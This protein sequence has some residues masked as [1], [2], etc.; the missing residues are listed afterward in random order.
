M[1]LIINDIEY[2]EPQWAEGYS[3]TS[4]RSAEEFA[5]EDGGFQEVVRTERLVS[6]SVNMYADSKWLDIIRNHAISNP[7]TVQCNYP[8]TAALTTRKMRMTLGEES[9]VRGSDDAT[10]GGLWE[11]SFTL[12]AYSPD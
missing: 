8:D 7:V 10:A 3:A 12:K 9:L 11:I 1:Q 5:T 2:P 4:E 6:I